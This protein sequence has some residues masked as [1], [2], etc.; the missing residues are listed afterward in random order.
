MTG[1]FMSVIHVRDGDFDLIKIR[2]I[3]HNRPINLIFEASKILDKV[4]QNLKIDY[5]KLNTLKHIIKNM[6][7]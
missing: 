1:R 5:K 3:I 7:R 6:L 4:D 2:R